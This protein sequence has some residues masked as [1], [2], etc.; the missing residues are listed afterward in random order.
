MKRKGEWLVT[1]LWCS[2]NN[3]CS[4]KFSLDGKRW[5]K[6][7][8]PKTKHLFPTPDDETEPKIAI[9]RTK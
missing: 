6:I 9:I 7:S 2:W 1:S 8:P 4:G 3:I 5:Y